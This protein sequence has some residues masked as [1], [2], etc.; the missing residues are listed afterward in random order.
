MATT[1]RRPNGVAR[2]NASTR[3]AASHRRSPADYELL[4]A[5]R[6]GDAAARC[7][8]VERYLGLVKS[9]ARRYC[10]LGLPV[11]DL[12]QEG[13]IGLLAAIDHFD[14]AHG[15]AFSTYAFWRIRQA[16]THALTTNGHVLRLPKQVL[17][18]RRAV[19]TAAASLANAGRSRTVEALAAATGLVP[20]AVAEA[21]GAPFMVSSLDEPLEDGMSL[22]SAIADPAAVDPEAQALH[23]IEEQL[24]VQ[25]VARL[26]ERQRR[27]IALHFGLGA[28]PRT[29]SAVG[30]VL[31]VSPQRAR[32]LEHEAL[33]ALGRQMRP[34][35]GARPA[36]APAAGP[37]RRPWPAVAQHYAERRAR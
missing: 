20:D 36:K 8:L 33:A 10:G 12:V 34:S 28:E 6:T 11:E 17:E 29:L 31:H 15:A 1:A 2:Q 26:P 23:H 18:D 3:A 32:A 5:A 35:N 30:D 37:V 4:D 9:I 14:P 24:L 21:L 25:A 7:E 19:V 16:V 22:E 13:S 27:V